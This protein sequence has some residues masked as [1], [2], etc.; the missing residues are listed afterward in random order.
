M[1]FCAETGVSLR[2]HNLSFN[3]SRGRVRIDGGSKKA[4]TALASDRVASETHHCHCPQSPFEAALEGAVGFECVGFS[5]FPSL[6]FANVNGKG[7]AIVY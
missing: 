4:P 2:K 7:E 6:S 5:L 1:S 3:N